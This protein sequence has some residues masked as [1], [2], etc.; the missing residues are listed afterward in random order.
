M[1]NYQNFNF[2]TAG[3]DVVIISFDAFNPNQAATV[4][5]EAVLNVY[6]DSN[7]NLIKTDN[8]GLVPQDQ[9]SSFSTSL[10]F[11][12]LQPGQSCKVEIVLSNPTSS[13]IS[14]ETFST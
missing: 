2:T 8:I 13:I 5:V 11:G 7:K 1:L 3:P 14:S 4:G 10:P 9:L 12:G 6:N